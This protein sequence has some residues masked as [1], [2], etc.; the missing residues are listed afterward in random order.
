MKIISK[1]E[2]DRIQDDYKGIFEDFQETH[3]EWKGR[4]AAFLPG[5]GT[6]LSIEGIHF[7][8]DGDYSHLPVLCKA[9]ACVGACYQFAGGYT[10]VKRIYRLSE[11][12]ARREK[13]VYLDR[14]ETDSGDFALPG[15][16]IRSD[17]HMVEAETI[18]GEKISVICSQEV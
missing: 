15:S 11:A 1:A 2:F 8:V 12:Q 3:P 14:V 17:L 9:N 10:L 13:A 4:R 18:G 5:E 6:T 16:D 7:L